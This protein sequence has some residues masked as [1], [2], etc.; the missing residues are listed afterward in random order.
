M[1]KLSKTTT[2]KL[3]TLAE[4]NNI[5]TSEFENENGTVYILYG[6]E[7]IQLKGEKYK[8][9]VLCPLVNNNYQLHCT[10]SEIEIEELEEVFYN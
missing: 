8:F 6:A 10:S 3:L 1:F 5:T 2:T 4:N 9:L 7:S